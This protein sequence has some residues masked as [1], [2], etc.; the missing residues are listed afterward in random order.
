MTPPSRGLL[1]ETTRQRYHSAMVDCDRSGSNEMITLNA[2]RAVRVVGLTPIR[3]MNLN[4]A[5][6]HSFPLAHKGGRTFPATALE[7]RNL[8]TNL[9][10]LTMM[11][12]CGVEVLTTF[13]P[14]CA[15]RESHPWL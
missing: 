11:L 12:L 8:A 6:Q 15:C 4:P 3:Y 5:R 13:L 7:I 2:L 14:T 9:A 10:Y 1:A